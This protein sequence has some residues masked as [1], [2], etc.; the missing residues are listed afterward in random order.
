[1][2]PIR[3]EGDKKVPIPSWGSHVDQMIREAQARGE[4]DNLPG[5]GKP[6]P[7]DDNP[8][9]AEWQSAF[10]MA[11]NA[12]AAPLWVELEAEISADMAALRAM[13]ER[14]ARHLQIQ[15]A[16]LGAPA[17]A[18]EAA[19][20]AEGKE[21]SAGRH[22]WPFGGRRNRCG[23]RAVAPDHALGP[24][25]LAEV[26]AERQRARALYVAKAAELDTK[27]QDYNTHRPRELSWLEKPRLLPQAAAQQF[28]ALCPPLGVMC[29]E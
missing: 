29:D 24:R 27:I 10:R 8:F 11:K 19:V 6:L 14:T 2:S 7:L 26:E 9:A 25:S 22:R 4:F 13:A 1:M 21:G 28:D 23:Q 17:S 5:A 20:R 15:V 12:G 16:R 18:P 3:H